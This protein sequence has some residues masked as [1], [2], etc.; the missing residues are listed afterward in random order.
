MLG[1]FRPGLLFIVRWSHVCL[2]LG[3]GMAT[4]AAFQ[5]LTGALPGTGSNQSTPA[6]GGGAHSPSAVPENHETGWSC[7]AATARQDAKTERFRENRTTVAQ[8]IQRKFVPDYVAFK[9]P[10][11]RTHFKSILKFVLTPAAMRRAFGVDSKNSKHVAAPLADWPYLD[12]MPLCDVTRSSVQNAVSEALNRGYSIQTAIHIRN[13]IR[14]LFTHAAQTRSFLGENPALVIILPRIVRKPQ[15]VLTLDELKRFLEVARYPEREIAF[16]VTLTSMTISEICG[17][18]WKH[19]NASDLRRA[20]GCD[21]VEAKTIA[22]RMHSGRGKFGPVI[23]ARKR[24]IRM[25]DIH[26]LML[27]GLR[28]RAKFSGPDD[29]VFASRSGRPVSQDNL[30]TRKLKALGLELC[31]PWLSWNVFRRTSQRLH[32]EL[33]N[34][35]FSELKAAML[36][37]RTLERVG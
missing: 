15:N 10:A 8:Y 17:L 31:I 21:G 28:A 19:V 36:M 20:I 5:T 24:D 7:V 11:G 9:T 1:G 25:H 26:G 6:A 34:R 32:A 2:M 35:L 27:S 3:R 22:V 18:Q 14:T 13:V 37:E 16:M 33:G 23:A 12:S 29:F 4:D 30:G